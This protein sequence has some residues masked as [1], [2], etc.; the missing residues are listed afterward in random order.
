MHRIWQIP[1]LLVQIISFLSAYDIN[2]ALHVSLHFKTLL[3]ANLPPQLRPLPDGP[4]YKRSSSSQQ[5]PQ[6]VTAEAAEYLAH[7]AATPRQ[8]K[9]ED[10]Y[11]YWR[12]GAR[13]H[14]LDTLTPYLHPLFAKFATRLVDGYDSLAV[15]KTDICLQTNI[16]YYD[17]YELVNGEE[18]ESWVEYLAIKT[19]AVTVY[20]LGGVQWDLLYAGVRYRD[21]GG[22]KRFS[23]KVEREEGVRLGDVLQELIGPLMMYG[24]SKG[25]G[26]EVTLVWWFLPRSKSEAIRVKSTLDR[27][28]KFAA[29]KVEIEELKMKLISTQARTVQLEKDDAELRKKLSKLITT[30][31]TTSRPCVPKTP[32][33][34]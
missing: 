8:L 30:S 4:R 32:T 29:S 21:Y 6:E 18:N 23:V 15:G 19:T 25:L 10:S 9:S 7:E 12:E 2:R 24:M 13:S 26:Q 11:Y 14:V 17:L 33:Q 3:K 5:L 22:V 20:C 31:V 1:E 34:D 27:I 16:P 28:E